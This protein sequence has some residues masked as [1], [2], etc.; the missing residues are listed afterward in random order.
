MYATY[1]LLK[2]IKEGT[3]RIDSFDGM[4][5]PV[6][7]DAKPTYSGV[8]NITLNERGILQ[9]HLYSGTESTPPSLTA[10]PGCYIEKSEYYVLTLTEMDGRQWTAT[11]IAPLFNFTRTVDVGCL[12]KLHHVL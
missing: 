10:E 9:F 6:D 1:D 5:A 7:R 2:K 8:T 3:F 12:K 11:G 4:L